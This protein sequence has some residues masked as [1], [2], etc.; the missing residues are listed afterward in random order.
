MKIWDL[1]GGLI[2]LVAL[3]LWVRWLLTPSPSATWPRQSILR[4]PFLHIIP[5]FLLAFSVVGFT[6]FAQSLGASEDIEIITIGIPGFV[7]LLQILFG[8]LSVVGVPAPPFLVPRWIREQ[9]RKYRRLKRGARRRRW[10]DPEVKRAEIRATISVPFI[11]VG[12]VAAV[13]LVIFGVR[14]LLFL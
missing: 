5:A 12:I 7:I 4:G 10:Q 9:D 14:Y 2:A 6:D 8:V 1:I 3:I 13:F 11:V